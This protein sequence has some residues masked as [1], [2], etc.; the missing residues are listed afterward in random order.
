MSRHGTR[1]P[2]GVV[3]ERMYNLLEYRNK[4]DNSS[5]CQSDIVAL[6]NWNIFLTKKDGNILN[7]QGIDD[8]TSLG[9]RLRDVYPD[10]FNEPYNPETFKVIQFGV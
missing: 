8:L 5:L 4:T 10:I 9:S 3:I 6:K 1:H 7:S 2:A